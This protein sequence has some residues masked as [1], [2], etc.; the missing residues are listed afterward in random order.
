MKFCCQIIEYGSRFYI[1]LH[2]KLQERATEVNA[3]IQDEGLQ[4]YF[5]S[6]D[7]ELQ[8]GKQLTKDQPQDIDQLPA[9]FS[10]IKKGT[11]DKTHKATHR[12]R[13]LEAIPV[14]Q[15]KYRMPQA[16]QKVMKEMD[17]IENN[18]IIEKFVSE[19]ASLMVTVKKKDGGVSLC[20]DYR[21]LNVVTKFD[22]YSL[23]RMEE[24]SS[25]SKACFNHG[26]C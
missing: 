22:A 1:N 5:W 26:F 17:E 12:I 25:R 19:W 16:Y 7:K 4:E 10:E 6:E 9:K 13:T 23:P 15:K 20:V 11:P 21:G 18:G 2:K 14:R 3:V 24:L 8:Y